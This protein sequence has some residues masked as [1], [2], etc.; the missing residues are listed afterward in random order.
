MKFAA[1]IVSMFAVSQAVH[2]RD[3]SDRDG[4]ELLDKIKDSINSLSDIANIGGIIDD[5]LAMEAPTGTLAG[6]KKSLPVKP[7]M[8]A[9]I[10]KAMAVGGQ[11]ESQDEDEDEEEEAEHELDV[12]AEIDVPTAKEGCQVAFTV[13]TEE[14]KVKFVNVP[15]EIVDSLKGDD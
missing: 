1:A 12:C 13:D 10:E 11:G 7:D 15:N 2:L 6:L 5:V 9:E 8:D 4:S 14:N 3:N